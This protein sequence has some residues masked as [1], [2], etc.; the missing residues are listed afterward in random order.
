MLKWIRTSIQEE[1]A[2]IHD[3]CDQLKRLVPKGKLK[4]FERNAQVGTVDCAVIP[5]N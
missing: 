5:P 4:R 2:R 1:M 3:Y